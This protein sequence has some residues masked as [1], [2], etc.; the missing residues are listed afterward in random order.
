[1]PENVNYSDEEVKEIIEHAL[2]RAGGG[3]PGTTR[4]DLL[5][6][7]EQVGIPA[8]VMAAA[9]EE[10]LRARAERQVQESKRAGRQ[11]WLKAHA[12]LFAVAN[13]LMFAV[14]YATTPGEWW[15][16]FPIFF[17]GL[18]LA[19]HAGIARFLTAAAQKRARS[20]N[21]RPNASPR[22]R[23]SASEQAA[24]QRDVIEAE[25]DAP[26]SR[27]SAKSGLKS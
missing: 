15:V 5:A 11:R 4:Q 13:L 22:L 1:M 7:G 19:A 12:A 9:A 21:E 14:N 3:A 27:P 24:E 23:V 20:M 18:A 6:I 26:A 2:T 17:W 25:E 10:V 8:H 16:A